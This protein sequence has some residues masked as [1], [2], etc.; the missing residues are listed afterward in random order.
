MAK[1]ARLHA[2]RIALTTE[3]DQLSEAMDAHLWGDDT[4]TS[5]ELADRYSRLN[6]ATERVLGELE[7]M[8]LEMHQHFWADQ[9]SR[10]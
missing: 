1:F 10:P 2:E 3:R 7:A 8:E 6:S 5:A 9:G 4:W